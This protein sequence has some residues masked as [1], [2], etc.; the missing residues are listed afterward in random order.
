MDA[1]KTQVA[2][3]QE[4]SWFWNMVCL[5]WTKMLRPLAT[6]IV[7]GSGCMLGMC[8][9]RFFVM[10]RLGIVEYKEFTPPRGT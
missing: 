3:T 10:Q 5:I 2:V 7:Y 8:F 1:K 9:V 4:Q 6:G